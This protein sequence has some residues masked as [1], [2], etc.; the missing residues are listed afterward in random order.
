MAYVFGSKALDKL[1]DRSLVEFFEHS[2]QIWIEK[3]LSVLRAWEQCDPDIGFALLL[4]INA[5][6]EFVGKIQGYPKNEQYV[7]GVKYILGQDIHGRLAS[8][9][10]STLRNSL[11]H[12]LFTQEGIAL[13]RE[14]PKATQFNSDCDT[15]IVSPG[16]LA[17]DC[18]RAID[19]YVG[20]LRLE[21]QAL[22]D[23]KTRSTEWFEAFRAYMTGERDLEDQAM[24]F[25]ENQ[26]GKYILAI[27]AT[28]RKDA[29]ANRT[30]EMFDVWLE[31]VWQEVGEDPNKVLEKLLEFDTLEEGSKGKGWQDNVK[32]EKQCSRRA[33][34]ICDMKPV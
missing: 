13:L 19:R 4:V 24:P 6:P 16:K 21:A 1:D 18:L 2:M 33:F 32:C 34:L 5:L 28:I 22:Q 9:L 14:A 29:K 27:Y 8:H 3:P 7:A 15:A 20:E 26:F 25:S 11:A 10:Q 31:T 23:G 12:T 30:L 17:V